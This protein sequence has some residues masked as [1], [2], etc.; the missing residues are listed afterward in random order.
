[1]YSSIARVHVRVRLSHVESEHFLDLG[2]LCCG[3][4]RS[5]RHVHHPVS[6]NKLHTYCCD[7]RFVC[8]CCE[9]RKNCKVPAL[10]SCTPKLKDAACDIRVTHL[11]YSIDQNRRTTKRRAYA[12]HHIAS[13]HHYHNDINKIQNCD[14]HRNPPFH[15]PKTPHPTR[16]HPN[17][18]FL[19][20][21]KNDIPPPNPASD[22]PPLPLNHPHS[23]PQ[24]QQIHPPRNKHLPPRHRPLANPHRHGR[25]QARMA[26][27]TEASPPRR[28]SLDQD[29]AADPLAS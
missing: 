22:N 8:G 10:K 4:G 11:L 23:R 27:L 3:A 9:L 28:K 14:A 19:Q 24:P 16:L 6:D 7:H 29:R 2:N 26:G 17:D 18:S 13:P 20:H 21:H 1:M 12:R 25:R 15:T 5:P